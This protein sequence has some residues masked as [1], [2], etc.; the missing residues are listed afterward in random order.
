VTIG[1]AVLF[2]G[3]ELFED[4]P[5]LVTLVVVGVPRSG[6]KQARSQQ[7]WCHARCL[8]A[9]LHESAVFDADRFEAAT[10]A[11]VDAEDR[12]EETARARAADDGWP[13]RD[14]EQYGPR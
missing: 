1:G 9:R 11:T 3:D 2:C 10:A 13:S 4:E 12:W 7:L 5:G 6:R 14:D 8:G